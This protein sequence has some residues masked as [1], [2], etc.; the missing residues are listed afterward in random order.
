MKALIVCT[1]HS[2]YP[3]KPTKTGVW[4]S[5][6]TH[7]YQV[8]SKKKIL[9]DLVSP[10]GGPIPVDP[11]S[12]EANDPVSA[13]LL[14]DPVFMQKLNH[15]MSPSEVI[16]SH[17]RI[18]YYPGG[19]GA[20]WDIPEN[21]SLQTITSTIYDKGG[22]VSAVGHGLC[23]LL[24]VRLSDGNLLIKDKYLTAFTNVEETIASL[25]SE[26]PFYLEDKLKEHGAV[27]T[28]GILPF[29]QHIEV[30]DRLVT[31]QNPNSTRKVARKILEEISEK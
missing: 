10:N 3:G 13:K 31:G 7:F 17:Y 24:N 29:I 2:T 26:A 22:M 23:G 9:I 27:L 15:S 4:L 5:E 18:V 6:L 1:N 14:T 12:L 8:L 16:A 19:H 28:K 11:R 25:V 20:M 21:T 30:D